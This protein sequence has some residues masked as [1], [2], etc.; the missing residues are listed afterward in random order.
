[1]FV[2]DPYTGEI[3]KQSRGKYIPVSYDSLQPAIPPAKYTD[4]ECIVEQPSI[5]RQSKYAHAKTNSEAFVTGVVGLGMLASLI[6]PA[7]KFD[8]MMNPR[9]TYIAAGATLLSLLNLA[10]ARNYLHGEFLFHQFIVL[11]LG[12]L[13]GFNLVACAPSLEYAVIGWNIIGFSAVFL[14]GAFN[15]RPTVRENATVV[16]FC[17]EIS[18]AALLVAA[19]FEKASPELLAAGLLVSALVKTSQFPVFDLFARTMEGSSPSS[20][21]ESAALCSHAGLVLLYTTKDLWY[22]NL[23]WPAYVLGIIGMATTFVAGLLAK[24]RADRKGAIASTVA[25]TVGLLYVIMAFGYFDV[26]LVLAFG[27][28]CF[29]MMQIFRAHNIILETHDLKAS[30]GHDDSGTQ[31]NIPASLYRFGWFLM[32]IN[33]DTTLPHIVPS[34]HRLVCSACRFPYSALTGDTT[35]HAA[36]TNNKVF[37]YVGTILILL[38]AGVMPSTPVS[39]FLDEKTTFMLQSN[40]YFVFGLA[41][42]ALV[43]IAKTVAVWHLLAKVLSPKRFIHAPASKTA[44]K[45]MSVTYNMQG[46]NPTTTIG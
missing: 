16:F 41:A 38:G 20:G 42:I 33:T 44:S 10:F 8:T 2:R 21:L 31:S 15:E 6:V 34:L 7:Y 27:H 12:L 24:M 13:V 29:R 17:Y 1:L 9:G 18:D 35:S 14:I 37:Q 25:S 5:V 32:R 19:A 3:F 23:T 30:L 36:P 43:T 40:D 45:Q 28:A 26:A 46:A 4:T 11:S 22:D 39:D